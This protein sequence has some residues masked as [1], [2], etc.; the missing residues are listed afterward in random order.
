MGPSYE[1]APGIGGWLT[2][3]PGILALACVEEGA[4][5]VS[6]AGIDLIRAKSIALTEYAIGLFDRHL[7]SLGCTLGSPRDSRRRGSHVAIRHPE[8]RDLCARMV[9]E[10]VVTDFREPD[11]IRFGL[12]PLTTRFADVRRAVD[13]LCSLL[14]EGES[15]EATEPHQP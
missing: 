10:G 8:A 12:A 5:L 7:V 4:R 15:G 9:L 14:D 6:V 13:V 2:G 3:T 1:P 11:S